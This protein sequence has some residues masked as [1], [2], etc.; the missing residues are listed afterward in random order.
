MAGRRYR[1]QLSQLHSEG[2]YTC[3]DEEYNI[4]RRWW[5]DD[6]HDDHTMMSVGTRRLYITPKTS[7][8]TV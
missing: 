5:D 8:W 4:G 1:E 3:M 7:S 6:H 2:I